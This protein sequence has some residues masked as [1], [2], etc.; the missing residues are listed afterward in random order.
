MCSLPPPDLVVIASWRRDPGS[1]PALL[2]T[3]LAQIEVTP[4][5]EVVREPCAV[6]KLLVPDFDA[7]RFQVWGVRDVINRPQASR[8]VSFGGELEAFERLFEGSVYS[9]RCPCRRNL[10]VEVSENDA[11]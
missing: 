7:A 1:R 5:S 3:W 6:G 8:Q 4:D 11:P 10:L 9:V 2:A